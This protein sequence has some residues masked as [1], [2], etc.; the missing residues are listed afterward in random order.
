MGGTDIAR[1]SRKR[2]VLVL[3][4]LS[5]AKEGHGVEGVRLSNDVR[6]CFKDSSFKRNVLEGVGSGKWADSGQFVVVEVEVGTMMDH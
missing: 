1:R 4:G 6:W 2:A 3:L 5:Y